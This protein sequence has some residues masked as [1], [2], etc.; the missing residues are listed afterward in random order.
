[1]QYYQEGRQGLLGRWWETRWPSLSIEGG[2]WEGWELWGRQVVQVIDL[3]PSS[4]V[5]LPWQG[6][7]VP[8]RGQPLFLLGVIHPEERDSGG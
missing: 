2:C 3:F 6:V 8:A 7:R 1:M 5:P 4:P